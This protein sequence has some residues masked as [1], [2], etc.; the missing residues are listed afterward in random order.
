MASAWR[1]L[2][3]GLL[4]VVIGM[5]IL[6]SA[7]AAGKQIVLGKLHTYIRLASIEPFHSLTTVSKCPPGAVAITGGIDFNTGSPN[8]SIPWNGP[9]VGSRNLV[10]AG[11]GRYGPPTAWRARVIDNAPIAGYSYAVGVVCAT[12][13]NN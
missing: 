7:T 11:P 1:S 3:I 2:A 13:E 4:G 8:V 6:S 10:D 5:V 12:L 9:L